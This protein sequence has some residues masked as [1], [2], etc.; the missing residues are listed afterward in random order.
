MYIYSSQCP[1][2]PHLP[3]IYT[4]QCNHNG[5]HNPIKER[6]RHRLS[7]FV[8]FGKHAVTPKRQ[9]TQEPLENAIDG[10]SGNVRNGNTG[11]NAGIAI[12]ASNANGDG[13]GGGQSDGPRTQRGQNQSTDAGSC[14]GRIKRPVLIPQFTRSVT[15]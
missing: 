15:S 1:T 14:G 5:F 7:S 10:C 3:S 11:S 2:Y 12:T 6:D 4:I 8:R 13:F 9:Q